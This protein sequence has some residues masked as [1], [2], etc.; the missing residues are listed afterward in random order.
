MD[1]M[2]RPQKM[3]DVIYSP[4]TSEFILYLLNILDMSY[5]IIISIYNIKLNFIK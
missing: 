2:Y 4:H 5:N 1:P 3:S